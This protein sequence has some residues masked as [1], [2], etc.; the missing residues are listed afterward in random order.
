M[1]SAHNRKIEESVP[2]GRWIRANFNV[3][4]EERTCNS[5]KG[6]EKKSRT[7]KSVS[8]IIPECGI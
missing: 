4:R 7:N 6:H 1:N 2:R 3:K 5:E 8:V